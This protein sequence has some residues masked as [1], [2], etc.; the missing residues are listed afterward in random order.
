MELLDVYDENNNYLGYSLDRKEVHE[1]KLWHHHASA[2]IINKEGKILLQQRAFT[3][4][5]NP[6][7]W[8][9]T[10]GHVNAGET[11]EQAVK[12]EIY[13]EIGLKVEEKINN[14][15]IFKKEDEKE[16]YFTYGYIFITDLKE[17]DFKLQKEE[18]NAVKY[19]SIE[20]LEE[21]RKQN[22]I[23]FTFYK[24]DEEGF[25]KQMAILKEYR[26]KI[27]E[28]KNGQV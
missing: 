24:W 18:V 27:K 9:R 21:A 2:W 25:K 20:E 3:K 6:G 11:C 12:R 4:K 7:K 5:K 26:N 14:Y 8:A 17:K 16:K 28:G 13:E 19:F 15:E 10:G 22:N 1:K 23:D